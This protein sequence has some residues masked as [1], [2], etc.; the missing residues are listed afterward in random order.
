MTGESGST[1]RLRGVP[2]HLCQARKTA[3]QPGDDIGARVRGQ[4]VMIEKPGPPVPAQDYSLGVVWAPKDKEIAQEIIGY[5]APGNA[6][7]VG[8]QILQVTC[9]HQP[10]D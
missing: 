3:A 7:Q 4:Y 5:R 9:F 1:Q 6:R 8:G 2:T 10:V